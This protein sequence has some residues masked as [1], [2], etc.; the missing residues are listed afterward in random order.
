MNLGR[1]RVWE[2]PEEGE[3]PD[4]GWTGELPLDDPELED[5]F[6]SQE[7]RPMQ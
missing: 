4:D 3:F 2:E 5:Q 7:A 6:D 1:T